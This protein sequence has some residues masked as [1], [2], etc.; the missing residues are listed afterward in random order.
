MNSTG[1]VP[2]YEKRDSHLPQGVSHSQDAF[3][4]VGP[5]HR[6]LERKQFRECD[7]G[8]RGTLK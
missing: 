6:D 1:K 7:G 5:I 3:I 8:I 2:G 4:R